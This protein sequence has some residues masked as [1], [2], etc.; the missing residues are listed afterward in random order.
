MILRMLVLGFVASSFLAPLP[1][2]AQL[3]RGNG[4]ASGSLVGLTTGIASTNGHGAIPT[5]GIDLGMGTDLVRALPVAQTM[6]GEIRRG[7]MGNHGL[8]VGYA[9]GF[10]TPD[11]GEGTLGLCV[12]P[13]ASL[14][15]YEAGEST[16][17]SYF[18]GGI[19]A[20]A[21]YAIDMG[22]NTLIPFA[23]LGFAQFSRGLDGPGATL[24][25]D[26][27]SSFLIADL[28]Q[29]GARIRFGDPEYNGLGRLVLS[30]GLGL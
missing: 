18:G 7:G 27:G 6:F 16:R 13:Y 17:Y 25:L 20:D 26:A 30:A 3:C 8:L 14:N 29:V 24:F 22:A 1:L 4:F 2:S 12:S 21:G 11:L 15:G 10:P 28:I 23:S 9:F 19:S 5:L